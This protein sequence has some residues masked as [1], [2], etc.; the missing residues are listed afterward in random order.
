MSTSGS[1]NCILSHAAVG[2]IGFLG[3]ALLFGFL[4]SKRTETDSIRLALEERGYSI[5]DQPQRHAKALTDH[6]IRKLD[7]D[8]VYNPSYAKGKIVLVTGKLYR[9]FTVLLYL[10]FIFPQV[11]TEV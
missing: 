8:S 1:Q 10:T 4:R 5:A 7:I 3:G 9:Y 2:V 6:N 11:E